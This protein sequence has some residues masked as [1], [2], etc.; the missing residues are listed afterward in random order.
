MMAATNDTAATRANMNV[1]TAW[2]FTVTAQLLTDLGGLEGA[3]VV[4]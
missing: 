3:P 4:M 1:L 2:T